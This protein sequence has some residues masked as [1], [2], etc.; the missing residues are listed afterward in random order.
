[1]T[2]RS[3]LRSLA[4]GLAV[5]FGIA[6]LV[7]GS[8][9]LFGDPVARAAA[10]DIVPFVLLF[11]VGAGVAYVVAGVATIAQQAIAI[12]IARL[13][14]ITT[15]GVF[16]AFGI[17][18]FTGG[19]YELRTVLAMSFRSAFWIAQTLVLPALLSRRRIP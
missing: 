15:V 8:H 19:A 3:V 7:E 2:A 11:N 12:W 16:A 5:A 17:Y 4:G 14:A 13:L 1:M 6:T 18:V 9:M 10:G